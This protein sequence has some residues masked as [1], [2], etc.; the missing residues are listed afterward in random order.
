ML[1][2]LIKSAKSKDK[3]EF[4]ARVPPVNVKEALT[5]VLLILEQVTDATLVTAVHDIDDESES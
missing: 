4:A 1:G 5:E 2:A 3:V